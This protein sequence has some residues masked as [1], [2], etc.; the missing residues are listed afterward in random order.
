MEEQILYLSRFCGIE[1]YPVKQ[2]V[3]EL[4]EGDGTEEDPDMLCLGMRFAQGNHLHEDTRS[5]QAEPFWEINFYKTK[6]PM[7]ILQIGFDLEQ[8]NEANEVDG[9]FYYLEHQPARNNRM[10]IL[11][12]DG[13]RLKIRVSG[14]TEDV[15]YYDGTKPENRLQLTAWFEKEHP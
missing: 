7:N 13:N 2:A 15:N 4:I 6:I 5:L 10:E 14:S 8:P 3:W 12:R 9:S 1:T 11:A